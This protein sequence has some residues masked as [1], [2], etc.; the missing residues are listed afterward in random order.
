MDSYRQEIAL[1]KKILKENPKGMTVTDISRK[2]KVN[3]NSVAKYLDIMRISGLVEMI[4]F[5]PA[6]VFFP[7]RR[8]PLLNM[9]NFTSD[10]IT[11]FDEDL[12][13]SI[14]N[15]TFLNFIKTDRE[16]IIGSTIDGTILSF[17]KDTPDISL[18]INEALEGKSFMKEISFQ[19]KD[20]D[21]FCR[22]R[23]LPTRF[24]DGRHGAALIIKDCTD[25]KMAEDA[26]RESENNLR[27]LLK[28]INKK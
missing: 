12:K 3:R 5:G 13:I 27:A 22:I 8:V 16:G 10:Y 23:I 25:Q 26:L 17:F 14:I 18:G 11:I 4:T 21:I 15:D 6:K 9:L 28:K 19:M 20:S 1:I 24:E 2:I 7:A